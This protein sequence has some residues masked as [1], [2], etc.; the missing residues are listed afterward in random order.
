MSHV[1][2]GPKDVREGGLGGVRLTTLASD[3]KSQKKKEE[4][5]RERKEKGKGNRG[6]A[7]K[8]KKKKKKKQQKQ[9]KL[10]LRLFDC[11]QIYYILSFVRKFTLFRF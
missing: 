7:K 3:S 2:V 4:K 10:R 8:K 11:D 9:Q 6:K 5:K 1:R